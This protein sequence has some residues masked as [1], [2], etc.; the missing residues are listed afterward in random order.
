M[1]S[2]D[3][4]TSAITALPRDPAIDER[5]RALAETILSEARTNIVSMGAVDSGRLRDSGRVDGNGGEYTVYY[6]V[7]YAPYVHEGTSDTPPR[8]FLSNAA[9]KQRGVMQ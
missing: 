2:H 6:D 8:P 5:I 7:D 3:T 9:L 1:G 4:D